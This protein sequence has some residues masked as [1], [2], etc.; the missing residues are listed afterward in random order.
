M[1]SFLP[2]L[3]SDH[4]GQSFMELAVVAGVLLLLLVGMVEISVLLNQYVTLVDAAREGARRGSSG[5]VDPYTSTYSVNNEFFTDID[6]VIEGVSEPENAGALDPI[7]LNHTT[8][9]IIITFYRVHNGVIEATFGPWSK[10]STHTSQVTNADVT[11]SLSGSAPDSAVLVVEIFYDYHQLLNMPIFSN[12]IPDPIPVHT[13]AI[14][15]LSKAKPTPV[16]P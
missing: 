2:H 3:K 15:P 13:Y 16:T 7:L 9:D 8:D 10:Y 14:M 1:K 4:K 12:V 11:A 6:R 5:Q